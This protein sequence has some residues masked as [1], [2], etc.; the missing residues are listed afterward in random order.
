VKIKQIQNKDDAEKVIFLVG[1]FVQ[2]LRERYPDKHADIDAYFESQAL[3]QQLNSILELSGSGSYEVLL[4][5]ENGE[6]AGTV[7][8]KRV[9]DTTCEMNRLFVPSDY[10][11]LN[12]GRRLCKQLID[13]AKNSGYRRMRLSTGLHHT[14]AKGL[15]LSL[16]FR[17]CKK[18]HAGT[19][20]SEYFDLSL[21]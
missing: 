9:D 10:R 14:E 3:E 8:L 18:F 1:Q 13:I 7:M 12:I 16:G 20:I 4:A 11:G 5:L 15:Y 2:W 17:P 19:S 21:E 6:P